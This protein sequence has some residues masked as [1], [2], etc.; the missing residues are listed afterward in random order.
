MGKL[1]KF[2]LAAACAVG[3]GQAHADVITVTATGTVN[4]GFDNVFLYGGGD[5]TGKAFRTIITY[6]TAALSLNNV[7]FLDIATL[8]GSGNSSNF[9]IYTEVGGI[10]SAGS[11]AAGTD[12]A[13]NQSLVLGNGATTHNA[14]LPVDQIV[15]N[16]NGFSPTT[17]FELFPGSGLGPDR[18]DYGTLASISGYSSLLNTHSFSDSLTVTKGLADTS[19]GYISLSYGGFLLEYLDLNPQTISFNVVA[20]APVP[21]PETY[22]ML[23]A[24][25]G[26]M[27]AV[28]RRRKNRA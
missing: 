14:A 28:S 19:F 15:A 27:T 13:T 8:S 23:I 4:S 3:I 12:F 24:G 17:P 25:L 16:T 10:G 26:V 20:T 1:R 2:A 18:F 5:M 7:S 9:S 22:A 6:D 21:E 11:T